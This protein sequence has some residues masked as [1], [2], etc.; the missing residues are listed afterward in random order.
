MQCKQRREQQANG[1]NQ[2]KGPQWHPPVDRA[3]IGISGIAT[4]AWE[5]EGLKEKYQ[6]LL[7]K[8]LREAEKELKNMKHQRGL[9]TTDTNSINAV[10]DQLTRA[11]LKQQNSVYPERSSHP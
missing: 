1:Q 4:P 9:D 7:K 10:Y 5:E 2:G 6:E 8:N 11:S 3:L